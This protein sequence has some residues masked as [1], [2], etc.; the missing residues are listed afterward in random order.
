MG[1]YFLHVLE[2]C[3]STPRAACAECFGTLKRVRCTLERTGSSGNRTD[4]RGDILRDA[5]PVLPLGYRQGLFR[6][7]IVHL[8]V[9][10]NLQ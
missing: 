10:L 3:F 5:I 9:V 6:S 2:T 4:A 8:Q 1:A 7:G